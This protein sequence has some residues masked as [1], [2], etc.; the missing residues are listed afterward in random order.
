M[1]TC[2]HG[3]SV[4]ERCSAESVESVSLSYEHRGTFS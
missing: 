4:S 2:L 3:Y 1:S